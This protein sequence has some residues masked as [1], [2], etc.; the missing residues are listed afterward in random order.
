[1][2]QAGELY[3]ALGSNN[4]RTTIVIFDAELVES[5][6]TV[7]GAAESTTIKVGCPKMPNCPMSSW[8]VELTTEIVPCNLNEVE[9]CRL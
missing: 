3:T 1:M 4:R 5:I 6:I 2:A 8:V 9:N 7:D